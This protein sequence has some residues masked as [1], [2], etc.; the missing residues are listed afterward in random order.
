MEKCEKVTGI[1][2]HA[3]MRANSP[4]SQC[5]EQ[6]ASKSQKQRLA[7]ET[8]SNEA[9]GAE[10]AEDGAKA[11]PGVVT[12]EQPA[13][14]PEDDTVLPE[15]PEGTVEPMT[16]WALVEPS[17]G[18]DFADFSEFC[19]SRFTANN[20]NEFNNFILTILSQRLLSISAFRL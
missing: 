10:A 13:A 6:E 16:A 7:A 20:F 14:V 1:S 15:M 5:E 3:D 4:G 11:E 18:M 19:G 2:S 8:T 17:I 9:L 12:S